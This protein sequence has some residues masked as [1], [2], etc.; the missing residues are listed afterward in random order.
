M[1]LGCAWY[2][3]HWDE[4]RWPVDLRLM[5]DAGM[6]VVRVGEF[7]WSR[8]EPTEGHFDLD[9][10]ERAVTQA[11]ALGLQTVMGTPTAA[12]PAWLTTAYPEVLAIRPGGQ[13]ARHGGRCHYSPTSAT[14]RTFCRRIAEEMARRFGHTPSVIG[15]QIDNEY[16]SESIDPETLAQFQAHLQESYGSLE[17]LN[18][19]WS[20]AYWSQEYSSW[21]QIP[22]PLPWRG[23]NPGLALEYKRFITRVYREFQR[24]QL[25]AIRAHV[26]ARQFIT[27]N[28][29]GWFDLF[30]HYAVSE[31]LDLVSW[32]NYVG[33]GH[34]DYLSNGAAHDLTRGFKRRNFW[35]M[36]TQP[37]NVNWS[38]I[39]NALHK[40]EVRAMAWH[41]VGHGAD[42]VLY[43]QWRSALNGQEQYHGSLV[44]P[45]GRPRPLYG[46]VAQLGKEF[47]QASDALAN[48]VPAAQVA[49]LHSYA[50]RWAIDYQRHH[51][52]FDP[53][54]HLL[55]FYRPVR[56]QGYGID[57]LHPQAPLASYP[58]VIAP[59][60][61]L[62]P[63]ALAELLR[64][65]VHGGGHLV[66][67]PRSGVKDPFN[68][69]LPS[70]QPG[71]LA[72]LLGAHVEEYYALDT[73]ASV[74]GKWG[75]GEARLWAEW[76]VPDAADVEAPL[77]YEHANGWLDG[78]AA[79]VTRPVGAGR[80][81]YLGT[82]LDET[83]TTRL[84]TWLAQISRLKAPFGGPVP[85][86]VEVCH[87]VGPDGEVFILIN[88]TT[89]PCQVT[90]PTPMIDL[91]TG[92]S[93]RQTIWLN[94]Y[95]VAALLSAKDR[96]VM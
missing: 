60:L 51:Q 29:M 48:T 14:Y 18:A 17:A 90:L 64:T 69:L 71:P 67:G 39:N 87:R 5:R 94:A 56:A 34:L 55:S 68:A 36:E 22:L 91:F 1:Q 95:G 84:I 81:T 30:D 47:T 82:W 58:L 33:T 61:Q 26:E 13:R 31:E 57:I 10:L 12:P 59:H 28:F 6:T 65:Y 16:N 7:A 79:L 9:W 40:G 27:H 93:Q 70:R 4:S 19:R 32:D 44:G 25:E 88:H 24:I 11:A 42:A 62:L 77:R 63:E 89:R 35:L 37:G 38:G 80:I 66:L 73:P 53:V 20:T 45:D 86:G 15:W 52:D 54:A 49:L 43:W 83:L 23:D 92:E 21:D 46:E 74:T 96:F 85:D 50:F 8:L 75:N 72:E 2:P 41:A 76:L 78:Q 3:E